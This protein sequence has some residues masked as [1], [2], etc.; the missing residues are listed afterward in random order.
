MEDTTTIFKD[1][2]KNSTVKFIRNASKSFSTIITS[3]ND[4]DY[5]VS[6]SKDN[7][8]ILMDL[9]SFHKIHEF[10]YH[11]EEI[12][13]LAI[14]PNNKYILTAAMDKKVFLIDLKEGYK[15]KEIEG[16]H[17]IVMCVV[18]SPCGKYILTAGRDKIARM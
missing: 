15:I 1:N 6:A 18:F 5:L 2:S 12:T 9:K 10:S 11:N 17:D 8:V 13:S 7:K 3:S 16:H 4:G 14:S